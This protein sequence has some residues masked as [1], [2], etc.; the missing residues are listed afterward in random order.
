MDRVKRRMKRVG[1]RIEELGEGCI[2]F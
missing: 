1:R 2:D